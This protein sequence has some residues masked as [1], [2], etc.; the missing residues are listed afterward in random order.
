MTYLE[1]CRLKANNP[2]ENIL[3]KGTTAAEAVGILS[4]H[5]LGEDWYSCLPMNCTE[6]IITEI[7]GEILRKY[8]NP[9]R[10]LSRRRR[11]H[12]DN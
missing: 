2:Q 8:P 5:F 4:E 3:P 11:I 6:Q 9:R 7:V 12:E 1:F 10:K